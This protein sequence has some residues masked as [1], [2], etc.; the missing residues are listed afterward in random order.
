M[1][2]VKTRKK[3][4]DNSIVIDLLELSFVFV[5]DPVPEGA[6]VRAHVVNI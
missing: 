5:Y 3:S 2:Y 4:V 1:Y 6:L